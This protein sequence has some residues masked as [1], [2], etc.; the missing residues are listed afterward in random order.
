MTDA[1]AETGSPPVKG[2][3]FARRIGFR[4]VFC[5]FALYVCL[6]RLMEEDLGLETGFGL[7]PGGKFVGAAYAKVWAPC[8]AWTGH[9][10]LHIGKPLAYVPD[11]NSDGIYGYVQLV[12]FAM[13]AVIATVVWTVWD[14]KATEYKR[15][16]EW[17]R[18]VLRYALAFSLLNY[19]MVKVIPV[20]FPAPRLIDLLRTHGDFTPFWLFWTFMGYS[21][22]Y[23]I[24]AGAAEVLAGV[25]LLFRRTTTLGA[26]A[27]VAVMLNVVML[28]FCYQV[29]E[30][31][32]VIFLFLMTVILLAPDFGRLANLLVLNRATSPV[33]GPGPLT[34][35]WMR[36]ASAGAK[37][38]IIAYMVFTSVM[39]PLNLKAV[40]SPNSPLFGIYDVEEFSRNGQVTP[41]LST[42]STRWKKVVFLTTDETWI[43]KM[44]DSWDTC[45]TAYDLA[46]KNMTV[47]FNSGQKEGKS[48]L[49]YAQ[50]DR[51]HMTLSGP[52]G[53]DSLSAKLKRIDDSKFKLVR[54]R[55]RWINGFP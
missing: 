29:P 15:L 41:P 49:A 33:E 26:L 38:A 9:H 7:A 4:F 32:D 14:R 50:Q 36:V 12:S 53:G 47:A 27:A 54:A 30:K 39:L 52:L 2:W 28:D 45:D 25:L 8:V 31:L 13:L 34:L 35:R 20:Q 6:C 1:T 46:A 10:I 43:Q 11:G 55:F 16:N 3:N 24:F 18:V 51:D 23:T 5:Y 48:V 17:M 19:G 37:V 21:T 44:D 42:D 40:Y 22:A